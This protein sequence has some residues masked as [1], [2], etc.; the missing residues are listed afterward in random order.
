MKEIRR[1]REKYVRLAQLRSTLSLVQS[2]MSLTEDVGEGR[3]GSISLKMVINMNETQLRTIEQIE[4]F[5]RGSGN[6]FPRRALLQQTLVQHLCAAGPRR[7][8]LTSK[9]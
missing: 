1:Q 3:N 2:G 6:L 4:Q 7:W 5:P 9:W 8:R